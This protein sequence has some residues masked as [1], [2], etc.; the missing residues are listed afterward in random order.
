MLIVPI[1]VTAAQYGGS[2][3]NHIDLSPNFAGI[4]L[5]LSNSIPNLCSIFG[6]IFVQLVVTDEVRTA[7]FSTLISEII[8]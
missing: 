4:I 2:Y 6:P 5:A 7:F 1:S 8:I 3:I